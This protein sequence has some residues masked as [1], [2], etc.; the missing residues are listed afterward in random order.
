M[1]KVEGLENTLEDIRTNLT[2]LNSLGSR[3]D[4]L[5][6]NNANLNSR[7]S[8]IEDTL[9]WKDIKEE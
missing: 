5:E 1:S 9:L 4:S 6:E 7:V 3:V 8:D 2:A